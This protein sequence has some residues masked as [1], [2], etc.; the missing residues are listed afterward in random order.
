MS[1]EDLRDVQAATNRTRT[2]GWESSAPH[3]RTV[4]EHLTLGFEHDPDPAIV[5]G[6]GNGNDLSLADV[7]D[8]FA[9]VRLVDVDVGAVEAGVARQ[10]FA[11]DPR[12]TVDPPTDLLGL[13]AFADRAAAGGEFPGLRDW[14]RAVPGG[15]AAADADA[16]AGAYAAAAS[17]CTLTQLVGRAIDLHGPSDVGLGPLI[18]TVRTAHVRRMVDDLRPA[19]VG[20]LVTDL[21][22]DLTAPDLADWPEDELPDRVAEQLAAGNHFHGVHAEPLLGTFRD[23]QAAGRVDAAQLLR[24]WRWSMTHRTYAVYGVK[25]RRA[26]GAEK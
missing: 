14:C 20:L 11:G 24:P 3:R 12:V 18:G 6:F 21:F 2:G 1:L 15:G 26:G 25:F 19:G 22:S 4:T 8:A 7:L 17:V 16:P 5:Y 13:E 23:E 9:G 10:G